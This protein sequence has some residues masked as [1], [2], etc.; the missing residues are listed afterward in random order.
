M[1]R[2]I[3]VEISPDH[4][5]QA[6]DPVEI[7]LLVPSIHCGGCIS[8][9]ERR[10]DALDGVLSARVNLTAKR[11]RA[12]I[13]PDRTSAEALIEALT[14]AG[15]EARLFEPSVHGEAA[16]D[17]TGRDLLMRIAVAGFASMNIMLLSV[18]VWSGAE[19]ATRDILHW[20]SGL[21]AIPAAGY[22]AVPFFRSAA[23]ALKHG[24]L[25]MDVPISLA[26]ILAL[27]SSIITTAQSGEH[28]YFDAA[29]M[30]TFFLL[31]G[32]YLEH[33]TRAGARTAAAELMALS[34]RS[35]TRI[36][37]DGSREEVSID[38]IGPGDLIEVTAGER[39]PADGLIIHGNSDLDR[40]LV[41]GEST[42]EPVGPGAEAHAGMLNLT[43]PLRLTVTATGDATLLAEIARL[44]DAA[45]RGR[46]RYD[47]LADRAAR[48]YSPGVHIIAGIAFLGWMYATG[49][50]FVGLEI[51]T[52]VLI[53]TCPCALGLAVPTVHTVATGRLFRRGIYL[54]DGTELERLAEV[55]MIAFDKTGTL[56][57]GK[58]RLVEW[59][60]DTRAWEVA[61]A[62]AGASR[63][64]LSRA[65]AK[66]A[67]E[68]GIVPAAIINIREV[69]GFGVEGE[70]VGRH[71][72]LGRPEWVGADEDYAVAIDAGGM[73]EGF[74]FAET[75]R[76]DAAETC[77]ALGEMGFDL[78]ILSGD[79][80]AAVLAIGAE[81]GIAETHA[82]LEP[83]D[84]LAWLEARRA[85]GRRV[86]MVGDGL[87]DGPALAAAHASMS[88]A[89][90]ADVA[91]AAA[92]LVFTGES[93]AA[94]TEAVTLART[95]RTRT[96]QSFGL[97][98]V[99]NA[100]AM[101]L[102]L[103]GFVTPLIAAVAMSGSSV[104]VVLNALRLRRVR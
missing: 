44:V 79:A 96:F 2:D 33:R 20:I 8:G 49:S 45:E 15:W 19:P 86:L 28:A 40:A 54:K 65:I 46:G 10:L 102:A 94:V 92:G 31:I 81:T 34:A 4:A 27:V 36:A 7:E 90:A 71:V 58:P 72:R 47:R 95:A 41:T 1:P 76:P 42:P 51:A 53:I 55:D 35:A 50:W 103:A 26:I 25:G 43:G 83:G 59:P 12:T 5:R 74:R 77:R 85:E 69:P 75:L 104:A 80:E 61:A 22:A 97:A 91:Q 18:S 14:S 63:H 52:A 70:Y 38:D 67:A 11:A 73:L 13:D 29:V 6:V 23:Q 98:A 84:K 78:A 87:N 48:V 88:P 32:R 62:L 24:R 30:L 3:A 37:E 39:L 9:I 57:D 99:Y 21:L 100:I 101:P 60:S 89:A 56:T 66:E 93:L 64:P 68:R 17:K 16:L 82:R